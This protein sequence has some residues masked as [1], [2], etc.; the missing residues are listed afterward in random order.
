MNSKHTLM[1]VRVVHDLVQ[2][3]KHPLS[4]LHFVFFDLFP[5]HVGSVLLEA[6]I[7]GIQDI[8][9]RDMHLVDIA[10]NKLGRIRTERYLPLVP[11]K[12]LQKQRKPFGSV[13]RKGDRLLLLV[14]SLFLVVR[15]RATSSILAPSSDALVT[16]IFLLLVVLFA[17]ALEVISSP[18][19][20]S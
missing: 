13:R 6:S 4:G 18:K 2:N 9:H 10:R 16:S 14:A 11:S 17:L 15:P 3:Q 12:I 8:L 1:C 20:S 7:K 5:G 19:R